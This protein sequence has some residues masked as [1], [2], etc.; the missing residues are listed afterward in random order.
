MKLSIIIVNYNGK[1]LTLNCL[2]SI[3]EKLKGVE[4][5]TILV[6]NAS[7]D[8]SVEVIEKSYPQVNVIKNDD[9]LGFSKANNQ[10]I[11]IAKG[12]YILLLNNDTLLKEGD[13]SNLLEYMESKA[14]V[15]I[16]GC[17]I[18]NPDGSLQLSCYKFPSMREMFTHYTLLTKLFPDSKLFGDYRNWP[19]NKIEEVDFVIGAFFLIKRAVI[20]KIGMLDENFFLNAEES[21]YC[22]RAKK[23]GFQTVFHP[24]YEIIHIGGATK[25]NMK[26]IEIISSIRGT[27]LL[28]RRHYSLVYFITYKLLS[29]LLSLIRFVI[30]GIVLLLS[31]NP[32]VRD[33]FI[34]S[35]YLILYRV[36]LFR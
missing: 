1:E 36:G 29:F 31:K 7:S 23:A 2:K 12:D 13:F 35:K 34:Q 28:I 14:D 33:K 17:R 27:E 6:D 22:L 19:H 8:D 16:L 4:Y 18:N 10:G 21:E 20:E 15:G 9:N 11:K 5:E 3:Y 32:D 24:G 25:K 30:F 26:K